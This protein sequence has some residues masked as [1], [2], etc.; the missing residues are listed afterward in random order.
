MA[1]IPGS[2]Y[3]NSSQYTTHIIQIDCQELELMRDIGEVERIPTWDASGRMGD[4]LSGL[5]VLK[6]RVVHK[7]SSSITSIAFKTQVSKVRSDINNPTYEGWTRTYSDPLRLLNFKLQ[8][9]PK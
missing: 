8:A 5:K 3:I 9:Y 7:V 6:N 4:D 1:C 2:E